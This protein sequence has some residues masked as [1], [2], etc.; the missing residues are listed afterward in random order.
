MQF[1]TVLIFLS[2]SFFG[3]YLF[4]VSRSEK[5]VSPWIFRMHGAAGLIG[6]SILFYWLAGNGGNGWIWL[7][8]CVFTVFILMAFFV[9]EKV[10]KNKKTPTLVVVIHGLVAVV[11]TGALTY[12]LF[13]T[14]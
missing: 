11:L 5:K 12:S 8:A 1:L 10:F 7:C 9:F 4:K 2:V 3:A 13:L 14:N 6:L